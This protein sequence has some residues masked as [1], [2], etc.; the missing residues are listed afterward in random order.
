VESKG[1]WT[2]SSLDFHGPR[3]AG[4]KEHLH[5]TV[6]KATYREH[7]AQMEVRLYFHTI[8]GPA[9]TMSY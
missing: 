8:V 4:T 1:I 2:A 3:S 5:R 9:A 6:L 7:Q